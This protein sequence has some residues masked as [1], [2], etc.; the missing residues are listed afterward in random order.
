MPKPQKKLLDQ[1][2]EVIRRKHY[3][4]STEE[5]YVRWCRRYI[6]FHNKRHPQDMGKSELEAF[7]SH[8]AIADKV[9]AS[10]Q[11][12]ALNALVFLYRHVLETE[13]DF[14]LDAMRAKRPKRLP[15]VL[16]REEVREV[17]AALEGVYL[18]MAQ[19]LYGSG[20]RVGESVRLRV[21]NLDF[22]HRQITVRDGKGGQ[23]RLSMLPTRLSGPIKPHLHRV[24]QLHESDLA[25]GF[26]S[27]YLPSA[28]VRKYPNAA[29][30]WIWQYA[31]PSA[32]LAQS[33]SDGV[34]R[35]YHMSTSS[36][37]RA[38][39]RAARQARLE[40]R[41]TCH[42]LRHSLRTLAFS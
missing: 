6:L 23:D 13:I 8:L 1:L 33:T 25:Q 34:T 11:N 38:V 14:P 3:S 35:R 39:R 9:S 10:P 40:K 26:G 18:L 36:L 5:S 19:I 7:L 2:R 22:S 24:R 37:Q 28:L 32:R 17:L 20:L 30:E 21:K 12:Q 4:A 15:V 29:R 31:F 41:V 16:S 27:V 42:A